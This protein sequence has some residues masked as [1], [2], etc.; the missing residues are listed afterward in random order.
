[1]PEP[2]RGRIK[3]PDLLVGI[4]GAGL[5]AFDVKSKTICPEGIIFD[6]AEI[7]KLRDFARPFHLTV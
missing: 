3:G 2:L 1:V 7:Q 4:P 5:V 6:R